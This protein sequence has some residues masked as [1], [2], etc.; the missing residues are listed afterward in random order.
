MF[1]ERMETICK[2]T[3]T[4]VQLS[5]IVTEAV[6]G[7]KS[8]VK[9]SQ[10]KADITATGSWTNIMRALILIENLPYGV[11]F[12]DVRLE[13]ESSDVESLPVG[14]KAPVVKKVKVWRLSL[15]IKI[16]AID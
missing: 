9:F 7:G 11:S 5:G 3:V 2:E 6:E 15:D 16:V 1:I 4:E 14:G 8:G 13:S 12:S 10:I